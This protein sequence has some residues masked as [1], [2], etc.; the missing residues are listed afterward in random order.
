MLS[1]RLG[2]LRVSRTGLV[3]VVEPL[4][5]DPQYGPMT[6]QLDSAVADDA[7]DHQNLLLREA[8]HRIKNS[9][10]IVANML[11]LQRGRISDSEAV[12]ALDD[13][14]ARVMA[15]ADIH[16]MLLASERPDTIPFATTLRGL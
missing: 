7:R 16:Q 1:S 2:N 15:V 6:I 14:V 8:D 12:A 5:D 11:I 4:R 3:M 9:L 10:S 13:A